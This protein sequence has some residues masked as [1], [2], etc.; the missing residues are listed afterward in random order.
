MNRCQVA[1]HSSGLG[2][3]G[4]GTLGRDCRLASEMNCVIGDGGLV[5]KFLDLKW[6]V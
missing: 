2:M 4:S 5:G 1:V 6:H 3:G